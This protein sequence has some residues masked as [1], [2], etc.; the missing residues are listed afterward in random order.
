LTAYLDSS[1]L[2]SLVVPDVHATRAEAFVDASPAGLIVSDFAAAEFASSISRLVRMSDMSKLEAARA[3]V[4]FDGW[5]SRGADRHA[6]LSEDIR[7]A[8]TELRRL[9]SRVTAPDVLHLVI[10]RRLGV[11]L[12]TFDVKMRQTAEKLGLTVLD[13]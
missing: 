12:A 3:F 13:I 11:A 7:A 9:E 5:V 2:V 6:V 8:E 10:A 1:V 4:A